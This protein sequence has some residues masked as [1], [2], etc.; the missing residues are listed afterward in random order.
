MW[1]EKVYTGTITGSTTTESI[2]RLPETST[3]TVNVE[4]TDLLNQKIV[5]FLTECG[6]SDVIYYPINGSSDSRKGNLFINNTPFQFYVSGSNTYFTAY[7]GGYSI[8]SGGSSTTVCFSGTSYSIRICIVGNPSSSF[9]FAIGSTSY[10]GSSYSMAFLMVYKL[11]SMVDD[12][13]WTLIEMANVQN[14]L[15]LTKYDGTR[16]YNSSISLAAG[17][18]DQSNTDIPTNVMNIFSDKYPLIPKYF[19]FFRMIDCY[20]Y[21]SINS[22]GSY[23]PSPAT[24]Y[25]AKIGNDTY[26]INQYH[27]ILLKC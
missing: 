10:G 20:I 11:Q 27:G 21:V 23:Y 7:S 9:G 4:K 26:M 14:N 5:A 12:S 18:K 1:K 25:F 6:V 16:P 3:V 8:I 13:Y 19:A 2:T 24:S 17:L 22:L 15:Y